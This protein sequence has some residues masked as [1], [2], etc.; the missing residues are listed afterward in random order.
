MLIV[1]NRG[2]SNDVTLTGVDKAT[3]NVYKGESELQV[4][5]TQ[6]SAIA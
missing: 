3:Y 1:S 2:G 5:P 6:T 4:F